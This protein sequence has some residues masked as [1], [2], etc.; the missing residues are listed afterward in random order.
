M[1][2]DWAGYLRFRPQF[3]QTTDSTLYPIEW[4]DEQIMS[5]RAWPFI[6]K[7]AALILEVRNYPGGARVAHVLIA[8]GNMKEIVEKL[9]PSAEDWARRMG[10]TRALIESREG[11][12]RVMKNHGWRVHQVALMKEL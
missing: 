10:C 7:S 1:L 8:A 2:P 9:G 11:W 6:G 12:A 5:G 3:E 4:L